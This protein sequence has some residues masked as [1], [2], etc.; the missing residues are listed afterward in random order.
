MQGL[1][2]GQIIE[3]A[4]DPHPSSCSE[5]PPLL[6]GEPK[7]A[8]DNS[9]HAL[10]VSGKR[11]LQFLK[12]IENVVAYDVRGDPLQRLEEQADLVKSLLIIEEG[13]FPS[14]NLF[15][16]E[17]PLHN[18]EGAQTDMVRAYPVEHLCCRYGML[19]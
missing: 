16:Q 9:E 18:L 2:L 17:C 10:P 12:E 11:P 4:V 19:G 8:V 14:L 6:F 7:K 13:E 1:I 5:D 15:R 3:I